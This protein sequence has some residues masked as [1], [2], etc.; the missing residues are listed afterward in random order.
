MAAKSRNE[1]PSRLLRHAVDALTTRQFGDACEYLVLAEF[2]LADWPAHK[3]P[4]GWPGY[5]LSVS[6][7]PARD[8]HISVKSRRFGAGRRAT[9]WSF[10]PTEGWGWLALVLINMDNRERSIY[11]V[12]REWALAKQNSRPVSSG[13]LRINIKNPG[14]R[15]FQNNFTLNPDLPRRGEAAAK[16]RLGL[17]RWAAS[18]PTADDASKPPSRR[19]KCDS[20][21]SGEI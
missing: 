2:M 5:D 8:E 1:G 11:V 7:G 6:R 12:P 15:R 14:L 4:D 9:A 19:M 13:D 18:R 20:G 3:M 10:A 21:K 17:R 16:H